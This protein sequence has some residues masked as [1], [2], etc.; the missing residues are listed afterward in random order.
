MS[1]EERD[2]MGAVIALWRGAANEGYADAQ[3][4][5]GEMLASGGGGVA[6]NEAEA[7]KWFRKAA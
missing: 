7:A 5:L 1:K 2:E 3:I 4:A 6:K